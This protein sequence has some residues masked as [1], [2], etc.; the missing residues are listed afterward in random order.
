ML[1]VPVVYQIRYSPLLFHYGEG[2]RAT[3]AGRSFLDEVRGLIEEAPDGSI[4]PGPALPRRVP[5][6]DP[7]RVFG[8]M[9]L[10]DYSVQAWADL[11][12]P[13][14]RIRVEFH[15]NRPPADLS[16]GTDEVVLLLTRRRR[17]F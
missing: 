13:E 8:T 14:R 12:F 1:A 5:P 15:A 7:L 6:R 2:E 11:T 3:H 9:I 16:A 17:G 4:V 10:L